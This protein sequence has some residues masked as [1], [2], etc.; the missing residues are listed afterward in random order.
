VTSPRT[1]SVEGVRDAPGWMSHE[2]WPVV[3]RGER[4]RDE[5][6]RAGMDLLL[7]QGWA[8][9]TARAVAERADAPPSLISYHFDGLQRLK[10]EVVV[11]VLDELFDPMIDQLVSR[12]TWQD[13]LAAAVRHYAPAPADDDVAADY[14]DL[15]GGAELELDRRRVTLDLVAASRQDVV[16]RDCLRQALADA[17]ERL[18]PWLVGTG[19]PESRAPAT[20]ALVVAVL[21]GLLLHSV[22]DPDLPVD[23]VADLV[24][25]VRLVSRPGAPGPRS[26]RGPRAA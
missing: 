1:P 18:L 4:R 26:R 10:V 7:E 23:G 20:A 5:L 12:P 11:A 14:D 6:V 19:V 13:G 2:L 8:S 22:V 25:L 21:D 15:A 24:E 17:R 9:L 3:T 16:V